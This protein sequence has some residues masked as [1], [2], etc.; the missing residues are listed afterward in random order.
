MNN[1][2]NPIVACDSCGQ[3]NRLPNAVGPSL[4]DELALLGKKV[5][6]GAC[7]SDLLA[8]IDGGDIDIDDD[9]DA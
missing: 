7:K 1:T 2:N 9:D 5:I 4:A 8:Y 3:K 6:C